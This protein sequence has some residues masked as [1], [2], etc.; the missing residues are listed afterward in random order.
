VSDLDAEREAGRG[1]AAPPPRGRLLAA[2]ARPE[3]DERTFPPALLPGMRHVFRLVGPLLSKGAPDLARHGLSR[4]DRLG[5]GQ[6]AR[7]VVDGVA[8]ELGVSGV[9]VFVRSA[10]P[11]GA[12]AGAV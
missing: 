3:I 6:D 5:R 9:E 8:A 10:S 12:G 4:G 2:L 11:R 1:W 7:D